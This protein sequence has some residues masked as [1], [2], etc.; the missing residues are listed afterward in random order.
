MAAP[1]RLLL[2]LLC[3]ALLVT[4]GCGRTD[5]IESLRP[6]ASF[7]LFAPATREVRVGAPVSLR[8]ALDAVPA[9]VAPAW[10]IADGV[11]PEGLFLQP[12]PD[13]TSALVT[14][15]VAAPGAY[16][17]RVAVR[18]ELGRR[19]E[20]DLDLVATDD[21]ALRILTESLPDAFL[22]LPYEAVLE[23]TG[24]RPPYRWS[25]VEGQLPLGLQIID[26]SE[27]QAVIVGITDLPEDRT[28]VVQVEDADQNVAQ[29]A[30]SIEIGE[31]LEELRIVTE[32]LP[33]GEANADYQA[34]LRAEGGLGEYRWRLLGDVPQ[35]LFISS[36]G[37]PATTLSGSLSRSGFFEITV[38][39]S[40]GQNVDVRDFL[41]E[42]VDVGTPLTIIT[43]Q[44]PPGQ[45]GE[46]YQVEIA[47]AGGASPYRWRIRQGNLPRGLILSTSG[48]PAA[49][50]SGTPQISQIST[51]T[52]EVVDANGQT[53]DRPFT[54]QIESALPPLALLTTSL[55]GGN[56]GRL[57]EAE[58]EASGGQP[59]YAWAVTSGALPVGLTLPP[60]GTPSTRL[61]GQL[62]AEGVFVFEI[63]VGDQRGSTVRRMFE[64][65]V[66]P[67]PTPPVITTITAP[68][69]FV[70]EGYEAT[71]GL[72]GGFGNLTWTVAGG[73]LPPGV[74]LSAVPGVGARL[75]G[76]PTTAGTFPFTL[77]VEDA[78]G[79]FA[80]Q[81]L[82]VE[83]QARN[84]V[85]P[86][87]WGALVGR[88]Q[89][90]IRTVLLSDL[91][92][93][94]PS[95]AVPVAPTGR[96]FSNAVELAPDNRSVAFIGDYRQSGVQE[97]FIVDLTGAT[98]STPRLLHPPGTFGRDVRTFA[99][100][101]D[102]RT[103]AFGGD[104]N[105]DGRT[106]VWTV[107]VSN[108]AM[109]GT[110]TVVSS[111]PVVNVNTQPIFYWS[112][113]SALLAYRGVFQ[114]AGRQDLYVTRPG[115]TTGHTEVST[116]TD[117]FSDVV[118]VVWSPTSNGLAYVADQDVD[119]QFEAYYALRI[120][121]G[122]APALRVSAVRSGGDVRSGRMGISADGT[123]LAYIANQ[124]SFAD[125][126]YLVTLGAM[127]SPPV[128]LN[129]QLANSQDVVDVEWSP[130]ATRLVY[131]SDQERSGRDEAYVVDLSGAAPTTPA[132]VNLP[133]A[134]NADVR[135]GPTNLAWSPDGG[136]VALFIN[137]V[138]SG[139]NRIMVSDLRTGVP[140]TRVVDPMRSNVNLDARG[141]VIDPTSQRIA[142]Y[143]QLL[144]AGVTELF[145]A[146]LRAPQ[147]PVRV[148]PTLVAGG[149]VA[150]SNLSIAWRGD[151][152]GL[153]YVADQATDFVN[154]AWFVPLLGGAPGTSVRLHQTLQSPSRIERIL[155]QSN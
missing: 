76:Y 131:V 93:A 120:G 68:T 60:G 52:V 12:E 7:A 53:A 102:G 96:L 128:R 105:V 67:A 48:T 15:A 72:Q 104:L 107:D 26:V 20:V 65:T 35:G 152:S 155:L 19:A 5:R 151:G 39:V 57:Y 56:A 154:E 139:P 147:A 23:A 41:L 17:F 8:I 50:L 117:R 111:V 100:A 150:P 141:F 97:L 116:L 21:D 62:Q 144:T 126:L 69:G 118:D 82:S 4:E 46:P 114:I 73:M 86:A 74:T 27:T 99:Y 79:Q 45:V 61:A 83:V 78:L 95:P 77:R 113:D 142:I 1:G 135:V 149:D 44:V 16:S 143:G 55:P 18:D 106:E 9:A 145:V 75:T 51:F 137:D 43:V 121:T 3:P 122:L 11:L 87:R 98:P 10:S 59:P 70:C 63:T 125:E 36:S 31:E 136:F 37:T 64:V 34:T 42:V 81:P 123:R 38:E 130:T 29:R 22:D 94:T 110:P 89:S 6:A 119:N 49:T 85:A 32:F 30:L 92:G 129:P 80:T 101:P 140:Q 88:V 33:P 138:N 91:C 108:P 112:P 71:V 90:N 84:G 58:I 132:K 2:A 47:A 148:N 13:G 146:D 54:L 28:F 14:G 25:V 153:A 109:P 103:I 127:P 124:D 115:S 24:G 40:D 66:G 133:I 134:N